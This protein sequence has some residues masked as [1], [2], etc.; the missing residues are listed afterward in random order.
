MGT[1]VVKLAGLNVETRRRS[2]SSRALCND[3]PG[4]MAVDGENA[5]F[6]FFLHNA[7]PLNVFLK[8]SQ[9]MLVNWNGMQPA[10]FSLCAQRCAHF[11][12]AAGAVDRRA[13]EP[14]VTSGTGNGN[15][16]FEVLYLQSAAIEMNV[17]P[18]QTERFGDTAAGVHK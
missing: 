12:A 4:S 1:D 2:G 5:Y 3:L 15:T 8:K 18:N 10:L 17:T 16:G 14:S 6:T 9:G 11:V 13:A 7:A